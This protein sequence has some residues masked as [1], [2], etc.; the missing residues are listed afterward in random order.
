MD[1]IM[2]GAAT[3][4][5]IAAFGVS[6]RMKRP[7]AAEVRELADTM[8]AYA[9]RVPT[10]VIG[11]DTVDIVGTGGDGSNTVNIATMAAIVVAAAASDSA[12]NQYLAPFAGAAIGEW[13]MDNGM[14]ALIIFDDLLELF[15]VPFVEICTCPTN[16]CLNIF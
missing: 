5:Q 15:I 14:D 11:T 4:A 6:M 10:D 12:A 1:Q 9:R 7:S 3:P 16:V 2:A 13:F 8:L